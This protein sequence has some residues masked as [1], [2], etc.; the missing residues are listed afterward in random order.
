MESTLLSPERT[1]E[2]RPCGGGRLWERDLRGRGCCFGARH[3][4]GGIPIICGLQWL[5]LCGLGLWVWV[6]LVFS[7]GCGLVVG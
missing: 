7:V 4:L 5:G 1:T 6:V 3:D 2:A